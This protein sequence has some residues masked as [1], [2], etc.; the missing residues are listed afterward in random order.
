[1]SSFDFDLDVERRL[2]T[3][4]LHGFWDVPAYRAYDAQLSAWLTRLKQ[5]PG[6]RACLVDVRQF[7][8]QTKE[9]ADMMQ[10]GVGQRLHLYPERTVRLVSCA[11][12]RSQ[13]TRMTSSS[14]HRV[15]DALEPALDW[16]LD[17]RADAA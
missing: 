13:A 2:L 11:I 9:V 1:V 15:Y 6:P 16:L 3:V 7:A 5:L 12:S 10:V 8:V 17:R 14:A 4:R